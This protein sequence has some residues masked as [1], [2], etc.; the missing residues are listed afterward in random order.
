LAPTAGAPTRLTTPSFLS[1]NVC[2]Q[3]KVIDHFQSVE[4]QHNAGSWEEAVA[5]EYASV[6]AQV[7]RR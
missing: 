2:E 7:G 1:A 5:N 6:R 4:K 3:N